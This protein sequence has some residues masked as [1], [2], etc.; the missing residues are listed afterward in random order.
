M[1]FGRKVI[2]RKRRC[3]NGKRTRVIPICQSGLSISSVEDYVH[4]FS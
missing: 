2:K 1:S 3:V 4:S